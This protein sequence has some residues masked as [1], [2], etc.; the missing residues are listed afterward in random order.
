MSKIWVFFLS[1]LGSTQVVHCPAL[2]C[3]L[4]L[5]SVE[6]SR[7]AFYNMQQL[8]RYGD[9]MCQQYEYM[10]RK[11]RITLVTFATCVFKGNQLKL[12][13]SQQSWL[14]HECT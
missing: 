8:L 13:I 5:E 14:P 12:S 9:G 7:T 10:A 6:N 3:L 4:M 1:L 2:V 11:K